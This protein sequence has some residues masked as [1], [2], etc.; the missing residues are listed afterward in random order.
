[1]GQSDKLADPAE[2]DHAF[3][4]I[5]EK[6]N[7]VQKESEATRRQLEQRNLQ[8]AATAA[9]ARATSTPQLDVEGMLDRAL[10]VV[11]EVT[12][13]PAAWILLT[14]QAGGEPEL[15]GA[16]RL[17]QSIVEGLL[18]GFRPTD[19]DCLT[20]LQT[21]R[22]VV[23]HPLHKACPLRKLDLRDGRPATCHATVPLLTRTEAVGVLNLASDDVL[24][25]DEPQISLLR[26]IGRQLGV[27]VENARLWQGLRQG[28]RLRR[29]FV[30]EAMASQEE[31]RKS[32]ARELHD[33]IGQALTSLLLG[34]SAL[35]AEGSGSG[36]VT[37]GRGRLEDLKAI[38]ADTLDVVRDLAFGLRPCALDDLG[39]VA[40]VRRA[41]Y[42]F[43]S[44]HSL[45]VDFHTK[46]LEGIRLD[47]GI[48]TGLFR[49]AQEA[50]TNAALHAHAQR[51]SLLL[52]R[53]A[54][55][56]TLI[57]EDDGDGFQMD[58]LMLHGPV[59]KRW[60][61]LYGMRE[62]AEQLRGKLTIES[63]PGG[64]TTVYVE[65]PLHAG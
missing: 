19:C 5:A 44:R 32:I 40:A 21:R 45:T 62:R 31:E 26:G 8:L 52:E 47:P 29:Q 33:Q 43:K 53:R 15:A 63:A 64:G 41:L 27:A 58:W 1:M 28:D 37:I 35:E 50:L 48:E 59:D 17:P 34:L 36:E 14:P 51:I 18:S 20:V 55:M 42:A 57:V 11:L 7:R 9:V 46:G 6:L 49:I 4:A 23:V 39:L 24:A 25:L 60:L 30:E 54:E 13:L 56:V 61:G 12:G 16:A 10:E 3:D 38:V 2:P 65:V 22:S